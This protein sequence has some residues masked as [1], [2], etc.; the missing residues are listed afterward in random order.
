MQSARAGLELNIG[1]LAVGRVRAVPQARTAVDAL[2][3]LEKRRAIEAKS[4]GLAG[5]H[6]DAGFFLAGNAAAAIQE[7]DVIGVA[8]HGLNF[9]AHE[10]RILVSHENPAVKRNFRPTARGHERVV[11]R[12]AGVDGERGGIAQ[13][14][15]GLAMGEDG[16]NLT[17]GGWNVGPGARD[18]HW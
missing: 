7:D 5:T 2:L 9:S 17:R 4:D 8:G 14:Q 3:T 13:R 15:A 11:Q 10:K 12:D 1:A 6:T 16:A 18:G